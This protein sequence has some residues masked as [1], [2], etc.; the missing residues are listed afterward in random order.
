MLFS[1][2]GCSSNSNTA[3]SA[4]DSTP[5]AKTEDKLMIG[6]SIGQSLHPQFAAEL[7]GAQDAAK[8]L[9]AELVYTTANYDMQTQLADIENLVQKGAK[10][11]VFSPIDSEALA[12]ITKEIQEKGIGTFTVDIG[13]V[14]VDV[15]SHIASDNYKIGQIAADELANLIGGKGPIAI[16]GWSTVTACIDREAGFMDTLK[17]KYPDIEI[18]AQQ[19]GKADRTLAL[20]KTENILQAHPEIVAIFGSNEMCALGAMGALDSANKDIPVVGVDA[21]EDILNA[22]K[23]K[24]KVKATV[25]QDPYMMGYESVSAAVKWSKG[26]A[27][28]PAIATAV[29]LVTPENVDKFIDRE[30]GYAKASKELLGK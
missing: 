7:L 17:E 2:V 10:A 18:V 25:S 8:K 23:N 9:G 27:F 15:D 12:P 13:V 20:E 5:A 28:E 11:V 16:V 3:N 26:E 22:V 14:G 21:T 30:A 4:N 24:T 29:E 1:A 6:F 19:D